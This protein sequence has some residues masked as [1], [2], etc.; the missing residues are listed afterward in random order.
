MGQQGSI[1]S[2]RPGCRTDSCKFVTVSYQTA[3]VK[4]YPLPGIRARFFFEP[5]KFFA[6]LVDGS[7][8]RNAILRR[9]WIIQRQA[10]PLMFG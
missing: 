9:G 1:H 2:G 10:H 7:D 4:R 8:R 3:A 5:L 6:A